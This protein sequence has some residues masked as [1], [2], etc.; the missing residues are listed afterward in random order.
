MTLSSTGPRPPWVHV[1]NGMSTLTDSVTGRTSSPGG[2]N[3]DVIQH[4]A[5]MGTCIEWDVSD[6]EN[7]QYR[8]RH[9]L[10]S[11]QTFFQF[12]E[13][14]GSFAR[15]LFHCRLISRFC[16]VE[17]TTARAIGAPVP[18]SNYPWL[19]TKT[20]KH[21]TQLRYNTREEETT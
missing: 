15:I 13:D 4:W 5:T 12:C 1:L 3:D 2:W 7:E 20:F 19:T 16:F 14:L 10:H 9:R 17:S 6:W 8:P 18:R 21:F 11:Q